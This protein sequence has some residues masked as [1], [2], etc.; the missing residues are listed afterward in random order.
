MPRGNNNLRE[1][2]FW[3]LV[4]RLKMDSACYHRA[5]PL[6]RA[7][8]HA[9]GAVVT[10]IIPIALTV[11]AVETGAAIGPTIA[12]AAMTFLYILTDISPNR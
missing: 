12:L 4:S 2:G 8:M 5:S 3:W 1:L 9:S 11:L 7:A 10:K 6:A